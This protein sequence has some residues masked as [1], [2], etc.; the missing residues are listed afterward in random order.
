[1]L[2]SIEK[3][4]KYIWHPYTQMKDHEEHPPIL[5]TGA[6]GI[7]LY[8]DKGNSYYDTISSWWCNIHG[9]NHPHIKSAIKKQLD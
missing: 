9:H 1:M 5:L 4:K 3:D 6:K 2:K 8:D 7:Y